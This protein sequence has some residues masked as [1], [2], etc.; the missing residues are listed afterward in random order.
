MPSLCTVS[1]TGPGRR[2]AVGRARDDGSQLAPQ[3]HPLLGQDAQPAVEHLLRLRAVLDDPDALAVVAAG[4]RLEHQRPADVLGEALDVAAGRHRGERGD[5]DAERREPL[6]HHELVLRVPQRRR[7]RVHLVAVVLERLDERAGHVLVVEGDDLAPAG[8]RAQ[9]VQ[10]GVL[11]DDDA[12][13]HQRG[14]VVRGVGQ[15][16][17][18]Q[19]ERDRGLVGH[20]RQLAAADHAHHGQA[21]RSSHDGTVGHAAQASRAAATARRVRCR[22]GGRRGG[23]PPPR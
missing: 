17:Q 6:A 21:H 18:R 8:E 9:V 5:G 11:A 13:G 4:G 15:H 10:R 23:R 7:A 22:A 16:P 20:P 12:V 14:A 2:L 1:T 19:A 3:R